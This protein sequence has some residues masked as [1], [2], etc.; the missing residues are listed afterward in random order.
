MK[1]NLN[2]LHCG[3]AI[4]N[5]HISIRLNHAKCDNCDQISAP[6]EIL[7]SQRKIPLDLNIPHLCHLQHVPGG[8]E[9]SAKHLN[10]YSIFLL[11]ISAGFLYNLGIP[12]FEDIVT[13]GLKWNSSW[14][15][16]VILLCIL[17]PQL[18]GVFGHT[19]IF[20]T[21]EAGQISSG[22]GPLEIKSHFRWDQIRSIREEESSFLVNNRIVHYLMIEADER[23]KFGRKLTQEQRYFFL[24]LL[25]H[26][27][28]RSLLQA[29]N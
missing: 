27:H 9:A 18:Y 24:K 11:V 3:Q 19:R 5:D 22:I 14:P 25:Q 20:A 10:I 8:F 17:I 15:F 12:A 23:H 28:N 2:C 29:K 16:L 13:N 6:S 26:F 1:S 7:E 4:L 21:A